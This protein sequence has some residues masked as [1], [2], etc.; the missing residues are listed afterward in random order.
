[1]PNRG[2][3]STIQP[4]RE[5]EQEQEPDDARPVRLDRRLTP[6]EAAEQDEQNRKRLIENRLRRFARR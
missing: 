6:Q 2:S 1:M 3:K 5:Q 4:E